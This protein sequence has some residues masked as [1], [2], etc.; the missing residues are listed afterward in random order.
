MR[1]CPLA[2]AFTGEKLTLAAEISATVTHAH[3]NA[4]EAAIA[5]SHLLRKALDTGTFH[6]GLVQV[7]IDC[8]MSKRGRKGIVA[9]SLTAAVAFSRQANTQWLDESSIPEGDGGWRSPSALGLAVAAALTWGGDFRRAVEKAARIAGDSDSVACLTGM[10]LGAAG[11]TGV[12][13]TDWLA[14]LPG[15]G[16]IAD[17]AAALYEWGAK[18]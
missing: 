18:A 10:F 7:T 8:L 3:P 9:Q 2:I 1:I 5:G 4:I 14:S 13:P 6:E 12:L 15:R 17:L 16:E 11:G